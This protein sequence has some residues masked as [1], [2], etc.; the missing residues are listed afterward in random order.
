[1]V[2]VSQALGRQ[3][4]KD[5]LLPHSRLT[6]I[7]NGVRLSP[8]QSSTLR[9]ELGMSERGRLILS[10]GSLYPVKGH[11]H[12]LQAVAALSSRHPDLHVAIAGRGEMHDSLLD[13]G[14]SLGLGSR[15]HLL[16]L[17]ADVANVLAAADVFVLPSLSE[18]L[19]L[20]IL[21]AM[22]ASRPIVASD[23]GEIGQ[24]LGHGKA[25]ILVKPG[26]TAELAEGIDRLLS[27]P[28]GARQMGEYGA[29]RADTEY[30]L[31]RMVGRYEALYRSL[32]E[33]RTLTG[34]PVLV[35]AAG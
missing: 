26:D 24:V 31:E 25:G 5:L 16:G 22:L 12:L 21:E 29:Q 35:S 13:L 7:P 6:F 18:G 1:M 32:L 23:V 33:G 17:R 4:S 15:L 34:T 28:G 30:R 8:A 2:T 14:R 20:A 9:A 19:P 3:L 10:V 27:D 11:S